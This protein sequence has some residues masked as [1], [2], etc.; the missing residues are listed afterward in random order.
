MGYD[1]NREAFEQNL[2]LAHGALWRA[3]IAAERMGSEGD[4][5]DTWHLAEEVRRLS[6]A[7]LKGRRRRLP[8]VAPARAPLPLTY[9]A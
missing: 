4:A 2:A 8:Q 1:H 7:S 9:R 3:H 5:D 6:E